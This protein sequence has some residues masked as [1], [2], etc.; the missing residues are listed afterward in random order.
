[1]QREALPSY[2]LCLLVQSVHSQDKLQLWISRLLHSCCQFG[3]S[4]IGRGGLCRSDLITMVKIHLA[5]WDKVLPSVLSPQEDKTWTK[6]YIDRSF[7]TKSHPVH[8]CKTCIFPILYP[9]KEPPSTEKYWW[10]TKNVL[11]F[12]FVVSWQHTAFLWNEQCQYCLVVF[13]WSTESFPLS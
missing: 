2:C 11:S 5:T 9:F 4:R 10:R 6:N 1:M 7:V 12:C 13:C 3:Y 8:L